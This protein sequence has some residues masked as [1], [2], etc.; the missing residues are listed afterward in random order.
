MLWFS[1]KGSPVAIPT[2]ERGDSTREQRLTARR[3]DSGSIARR[4]QASFQERIGENRL[5]IELQPLFVCTTGR[6]SG[7]DRAGIR[8]YR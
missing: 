3:I 5:S 7:R 6:L 8:R 1:Q 2:V 4:S